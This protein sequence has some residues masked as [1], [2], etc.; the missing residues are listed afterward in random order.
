MSADRM[1]VV[2]SR[3]LGVAT[4]SVVLF[5]LQLDLVNNIGVITSKLLKKTFFC[6]YDVEIRL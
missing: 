6:R 2:A 3:L 4:G 5:F 1:I